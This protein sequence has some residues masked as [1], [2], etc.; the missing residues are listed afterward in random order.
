MLRCCS[1]PELR[2]LQGTA[3]LRS[4]IFKSPDEVRSRALALQG[5][6]REQLAEAG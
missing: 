1:G 3:V 2:I 4:E 6:S 5:Q